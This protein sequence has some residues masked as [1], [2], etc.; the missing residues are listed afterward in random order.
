[1]LSIRKVETAKPAHPP[2]SPE[3]ISQAFDDIRDEMGIHDLSHA[4]NRRMDELGARRGT[5]Q[6][7]DELL[8]DSA[9]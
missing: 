6:E 1:M 8:E 7:L 3:A 9:T 2:L 4:W 5:W